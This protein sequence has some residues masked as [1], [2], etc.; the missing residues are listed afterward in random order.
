MLFN[1]FEKQAD[2]AGVRPLPSQYYTALQ[3]AAL[4]HL[5]LQQQNQDYASQMRQ[6]EP[7]YLSELLHSRLQTAAPEPD[8]SQ[9]RPLLK[10]SMDAILGHS[11]A[12][13]ACVRDEDKSA[14]LQHLFSR[15][16]QAALD[17]AFKQPKLDQLSY[18]INGKWR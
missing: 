16:V 12:K 2:T 17:P 10:F 9:K 15:P 4:F 13:R 8:R 14:R 11:P 6:A 7:A 3:S 18:P 1:P 5:Q